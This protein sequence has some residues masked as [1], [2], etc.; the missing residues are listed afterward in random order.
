MGGHS[1]WAGIKHKKAL[2]DAKRGK[3]F[4]RIIREITIAAKLSGGDP[5]KNPRLRK[6]IED[7]KNANMPGDNVKKAIMRGTGQLPGVV[8]E[9]LMYEGYG[10]SGIAVMVEI[11]T[12]N[13]NRTF[14]EMRKIFETHGGNI[15]NTGCVAWIFEQ[16]GYISVKKDIAKEDELMS[17][18]LESGA[19]DFKTTDPNDFEIITD[20]ND[21]ERVK[22]KLAEKK[23][24]VS[25][26]ETTMLPKNEVNVPEDKAQSVITMMNELEDHEDVKNV[27]SNFNISDSILA[28]L[29]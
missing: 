22:N 21:F 27:Y 24:T 19:E 20:P 26:A 11:T 13:R 5:E 4:T 23:I 17:L 7:G 28:K 25:S 14:S 29:E 2:Q 6:A 1:H 12:D 9:E 15:G 8:Y 3:V 16:K 10:P 18:A